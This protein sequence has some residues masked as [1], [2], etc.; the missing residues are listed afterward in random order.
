MYACT[1]TDICHKIHLFEYTRRLFILNCLFYTFLS[2][3]FI[4]IKIRI[5]G[6]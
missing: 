1:Y 3:I 2:Y 4:N 6:K 5:I